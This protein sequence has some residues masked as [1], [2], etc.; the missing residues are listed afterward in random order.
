MSADK[1]DEQGCRYDITLVLC[2]YDK[3]HELMFVQ[4]EDIIDIYTSRDQR[5]FKPEPNH[6]RIFLS[7]F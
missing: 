2:R 5:D 3:N 1:I 6:K 4:Q 7:T